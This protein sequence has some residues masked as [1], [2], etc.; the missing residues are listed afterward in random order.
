MGQKP[1]PRNSKQPYYSW[2]LY[3]QFLNKKYD[4]ASNGFEELRKIDANY[5]GGKVNYLLYESS[6][7][8]GNN[9]YRN[10][11]F[12]GAKDQYLKAVKYAWMGNNH[13]LQLFLVR[14]KLARALNQLKAI[15]D[16]AFNYQYAFGLIRFRQHLLDTN[17]Q[18]LISLINNANTAYARNYMQDSITLFEQAVEEKDDLFA[19]DTVKVLQGD[20]L[21]DI[22]YQNGCT[23]EILISANMLGDSLFIQSDQDLLI[24][25]R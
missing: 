5:A 15:N 20:A 12:L 22:A 18:D 4:L 2:T 13:N 23:I 7:A 9:L 17:N 3:N 8:Y 19:Y 25:I 21:S 16:A 10:S 24:P 11:N 6:L 14:L 1:S